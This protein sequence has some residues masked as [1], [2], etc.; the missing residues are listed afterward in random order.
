MFNR[1]HIEKLEVIKESPG[2]AVREWFEGDLARPIRVG[3]SI[4]VTPLHNSSRN[5]SRLKCMHTSPVVAI[6][7]DDEAMRVTT[8]NS[9]YSVRFL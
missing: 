1:I 2:V 8:K 6:V 9:V 4:L 3:E 5:D 7:H